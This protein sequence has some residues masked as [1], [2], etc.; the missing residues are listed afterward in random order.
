MIK[1]KFPKILVFVQKK[2]IFETMCIIEPHPSSVKKIE[3]TENYKS[4]QWIDSATHQLGRTKSYFLCGWHLFDEI[5]VEIESYC[6]KNQ[7]LKYLTDG[8]SKTF[9]KLSKQGLCNT[10]CF[11]YISQTVTCFF[12]Y[13]FLYSLYRKN[14]IV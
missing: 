14:I 13:I 1:G 3:R 6:M 8:S 12:G 5:W 11:G 4:Y 9:V 7:P 10:L 2:N